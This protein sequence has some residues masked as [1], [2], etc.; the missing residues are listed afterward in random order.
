MADVPVLIVLILIAIAV[1]FVK[2]V[3]RLYRDFSG[4]KKKNAVSK[5]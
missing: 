4:K 5:S 3:I 2:S 1:V